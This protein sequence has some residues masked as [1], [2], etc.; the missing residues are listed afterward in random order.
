MHGSAVPFAIIALQPSN[1]CIV[2]HNADSAPCA[3]LAA[4]T[5]VHA[6]RDKKSGKGS[7]ITGATHLRG[8]PG[9]F[10][11]SQSTMTT[12]RFPFAASKSCASFRAP[13]PPLLSTPSDMSTFDGFLVPEGELERT[14]ALLDSD[15]SFFSFCRLD[16]PFFLSGIS[17]G[18]AS[19]RCCESLCASWRVVV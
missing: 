10:G 16:S 19:E 1:V 13:S 3:H 15:F 9:S 11:P 4:V 12:S 2:T 5:A 6:R 14:D 17:A 8:L 7:K 18:V